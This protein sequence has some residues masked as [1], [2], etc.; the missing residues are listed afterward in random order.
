MKTFKNFE[1]KK[2]CKNLNRLKTFNNLN[3]LKTFKIFEKSNEKCW[4]SEKR[5]ERK[6][7]GYHSYCR[8]LPKKV[9]P[10]QFAGAKI[11]KMVVAILVIFTIHEFLLVNPADSAYLVPTFILF[12]LLRLCG[13]VEEH[14]FHFAKNIYFMF[15]LKINGAVW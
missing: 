12:S 14:H 13:K 7:I 8:K 5:S 11:G 1:S 3:R 9:C 4:K 10:R 15:S 6:S 2:T